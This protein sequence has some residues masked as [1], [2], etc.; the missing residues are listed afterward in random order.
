MKNNQNTYF[1]YWMNTFLAVLDYFISMMCREEGDVELKCVLC[2][3][4]RL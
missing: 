3:P 2:T 4:P 1:Y